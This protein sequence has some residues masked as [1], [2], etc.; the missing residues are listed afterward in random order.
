MQ[1]R[2]PANEVERLQAL[3]Q[4]Q[5]LDTLE[6]QAYDDITLIA[7]EIAQT[8]IALV[9]FVDRERQWFKSKL[10]LE[11]SETPRELAFC[12]HAIL[13]MDQPLQVPDTTKDI[14][15]VDNA[16]VTGAP[17][18]Q[19]YFGAPLVTKDHFALGTL[20]VID[21]RPRELSPA[22]IAALE[23]LSRQVMAQLELRL[24]VAQ[25]HSTTQELEEVNR[26]LRII[27]ATDAL[28]SLGNRGAFNL[29]LEHEI[30]RANRYRSPL[31]LLLL[32]VDHFKQYNDAFGHLEGDTVLQK[33]SFVLNDFARPSD[34]AARFGG[35]EFTVL[36]P[37]TGLEGALALAERL[38]QVVN[39]TVFLHRSI[40]VSIG[41]AN[42]PEGSQDAK[43]LIAAADKALYRAKQDGRNRVAASSLPL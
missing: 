35:E 40:T 4:Y 28:T 24:N 29:R 23:A 25:L 22:Q 15:F 41:V 18:I 2:L 39:D 5:I 32:D 10:G 31:S 9:S 14:R 11:V 36:L 19:F 20:C 17:D 3:A 30:Y 7:A 8:P 33:L 13:T 27:G 26:R 1:A 12:A 43:G 16:L 34:F 6:E 42:L 37:S 38:R 21:Q